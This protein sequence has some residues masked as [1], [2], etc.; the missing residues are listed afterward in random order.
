M[1]RLSDDVILNIVALRLKGETHTQISDKTGVSTSTISKYLYGFKK[2]SHGGVMKER[3]SACSHII[4]SGLRG[5]MV[6]NGM[7]V[8]ELSKKCG[9][10]YGVLN[11]SLSGKARLSK[12]TIDA[13]LNKTG[14]KY[15]E[16]F[17]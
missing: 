15:E 6:K 14:K 1:K 2:S 16:L 9:I 12:G 8:K 5:Y 7:S 10:S 11:N 4:Y 17:K 3:A 13:I